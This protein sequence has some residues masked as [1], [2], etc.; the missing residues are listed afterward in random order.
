MEKKYSL[1]AVFV[2]RISKN[3]V[4]RLIDKTYEVKENSRGKEEV[5][6]LEDVDNPDI[7]ILT[8]NGILKDDIPIDVPP[9]RNIISIHRK[10]TNDTL[11]TINALNCI[12]RDET[13]KD[14]VDPSYE[15]DWGNPKFEEKLILT[16]GDELVYISTRVKT[17]VDLKKLDT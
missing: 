16:K 3:K 15:V 7:Y 12:V 1:F 2:P 11:Y 5:F 14:E 10:K 17:K 4:L 6:I 8:F 9:I 13:G